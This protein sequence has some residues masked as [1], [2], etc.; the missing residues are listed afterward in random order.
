MHLYI[1]YLRMS[2]ANL[3]TKIIRSLQMIS[4]KC[5]SQSDTGPNPNHHL[6]S[7]TQRL[8]N[9]ADDMKLKSHYMEYQYSNASD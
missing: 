8:N 9:Q 4:F 1:A 7:W 5:I 3:D 2:S 6:A